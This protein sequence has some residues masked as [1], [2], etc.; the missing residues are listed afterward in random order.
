MIRQ[1][2]IP[3]HPGAP[4]H[5]WFIHADPDV[6]V[7]PTGL[8]AR[9]IALSSHRGDPQARSPVDNGDT[10]STLQ[11]ERWKT[12]AG[13]LQW[14]CGAT[15]DLRGARRDTLGSVADRDGDLASAV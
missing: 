7:P 14:G 5:C 2:I 8:V 13:R 10:P 1:R 11:V 9:G 12:D 4:T 6:P 15:Y 3:D